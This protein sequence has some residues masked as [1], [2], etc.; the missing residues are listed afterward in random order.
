METRTYIRAVDLNEAQLQRIT[1]AE[2]LESRPDNNDGFL[3]YLPHGA[4]PQPP[5]QEV[6]PE[7]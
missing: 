6:E 2:L 1:F 3:Q 4:T 7:V 5:K